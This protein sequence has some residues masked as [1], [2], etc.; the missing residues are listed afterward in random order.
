MDEFKEKMSID[1][2]PANAGE[3]LKT[4]K[5]MWNEALDWFFHIAAAVIVGLL[6]V[7]F[8]AQNT[9]VHDISM[10]PTLSEGNN[11]LVEK[12]GFR[13]GWL[14]QGDIIV[15]K[16][17]YEDRLLIKRLVALEG[18]TVEVREGKVYVNGELFLTGLPDEPDTPDGALPE[19]TNLTV[20]E[21]MVYILG[22]NRQYSLDSTE[23][24]PIEMDWIK[25]RAI[26]RF[27]PFNKFGTID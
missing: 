11:V 21:G 19:Y 17:P 18:D 22:D 5:K 15:F 12:L 13:F 20:P 4:T 25:G 7:T 10:E 6:I 9:I 27:Y 2:E 14:K 3:T 16:S 24:G 26:F 1:E 23:F 8:V